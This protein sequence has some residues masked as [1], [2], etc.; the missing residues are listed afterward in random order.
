VRL[1]S[2]P[3][4]YGSNAVRIR[5]AFATAVVALAACATETAPSPEAGFHD[6]SFTE[7]SRGLHATLPTGWVFVAPERYSGIGKAGAQAVG[8][9]DSDLASNAA[10]PRTRKKI[11][12]VMVNASGTNT[13]PESILLTA[14]AIPASYLGMTN[15]TYALAL[16]NH[17]KRAGYSLDQKAPKSVEISGSHFQSVQTILPLGSGSQYQSYLIRLIGNEILTFVATYYQQDRRDALIRIIQ[18]FDLQ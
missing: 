6:N 4:G 7:P 1:S 5:S 13:N 14:E 2:K 8:E 3:S 16:R 15:E 18:S 17:L 12:F 9:R 11:L 10:E